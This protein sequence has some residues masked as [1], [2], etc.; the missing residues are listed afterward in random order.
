MKR[1][2]LLFFAFLIK[3]AGNAQTFSSGAGLVATQAT[4]IT[5]WSQPVGAVF[6]KDGNQLFVWEKAGIVYVCKRNAQGN[7]IRQATPVINISEEVG[8]WRDFGLLGFALDPQFHSN[9]RIYLYYV[10]DRHFLMAKDHNQGTYNAGTNEYYKATIGRVTRYNTTTSSGNLIA[11]SGSRKVLLGETKKTGV[12]ILHESHGTGSLAFAADGTLLLT[13]GDGASYSEVDGGNI[14]HTYYQQALTDSIIRKEENVGAFRSQ[15]LNS[16]NGKLLR[17]D[18]ETGD[19]VSSNPFFDESTPRSAK[20]RVWSF[21]LRNPFR[22]SVKPGSGSTNP[23]AGDIGEV[24]IGDVGWNAWE[25]INV[26]TRPGQNF[27]WP[28]YEGHT[29]HS[30]Y[31]N[32]N[33]LNRDEPNPLFNGSSC[34]REFFRFNELI[35][36]DNAEKNSAVFNPCDNNQQIGIGNRFIHARPSIDWEHKNGNRARV[37]KFNAAGNAITMNIGS[38][39]SGT[40]GS[41]FIGN[42]TSGGAWY[43]GTANSFPADY[44]NT[45]IIAD[46]DAKWIR[47]L[48]FSSSDGVSRVDNIATAAGPVVCMVENPLDG[49]IV[50]VDLTT[51]K[52]ISFGGNIPPVAKAKSDKIYGPS[53]LTVKFDATD[54]YDPTTGPNGGIKSYSWSF[55]DISGFQNSNSST[56]AVVTRRFSASNGSPKKYVV[57]LTVTDKQNAV[58]TD[59]I[60]ISVNNT[61]PVVTITSPEKGSKYKV[62]LD[63]LYSLKATVIDT[64]HT[65]NQLSYAW[66]TT[67]RHND[68][69]HPEPI[70]ATKETS[71]VISR[72]GC[73]GDDYYWLVELSVTDGAGLMAKDSSKIFP[74]C[75]GAL[76]LFLHK[77]GVVQQG[78]GNVIK[79]TTQLESNM[80]YFE[81]ERSS[82]GI[83]FMPIYRE[84]SRNT[85]GTNEYS[86]TDK[87]PGVGVNYYRLRMVEHGNIIRYSII[88]KTMEGTEAE[89]LKV[90]P[91]PVVDNFSI[92]YNSRS[93]GTATIVIK[94]AAGIIVQRLVESVHKGNN[95]VYLQNLP[96]WRPGMYIVTVQQDNE[97]QHAKFIKAEK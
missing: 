76:P 96:Q 53:E 16:H 63:T 22:M 18:P 15:M 52:K 61:P 49:S 19:G 55:G 94:D 25:E 31:N 26:A 89:A 84:P 48:S 33:T 75:A 83:R 78:N 43:S 73:N 3:S 32:T 38:A 60:I 56:D 24:F 41:P 97:I 57:K 29:I 39:G 50:F 74:D 66:Q 45:L 7:Y 87:N 27:G 35:R 62:G 86:F 2:L 70:D 23:S 9:G 37:G 64:E 4:D 36:Q 58:S 71:S 54:S 59:S 14:G 69:E 34:G 81:V 5:N 67:L 77:F 88:A 11:Q 92:T 93:N 42:S 80:E 30:G 91:N 10:V 6:S 13:S 17:I 51:V 12:P 82:D 90:S 79:W 44:K 21:G 20:S 95:V 46:Y 1:V 85:E 68:H 8:N 40:T 65:S 28:I 47:R 72:I